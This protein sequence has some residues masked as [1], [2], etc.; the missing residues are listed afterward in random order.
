V[1]V[2]ILLPKLVVVGNIRMQTIADDCRRLQ[3]IA[4]HFLG[5][6]PH[7]NAIAL[8]AGNALPLLSDVVNEPDCDLVHV[9]AE[10]RVQGYRQGSGSLVSV[11]Y[12]QAQERQ[13]EHDRAGHFRFDRA[14][15]LVK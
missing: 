13:L 2:V 1:I 3:T 14:D 10:N 11:G 9:L 6:T 8:V 4:D 7:L 5:R 12:S 15:T